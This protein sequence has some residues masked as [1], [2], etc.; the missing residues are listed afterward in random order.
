MAT[1]RRW[2]HVEETVFHE[3]LGQYRAVDRGESGAAPGRRRVLG[4]IRQLLKKPRRDDWLWWDKL[5]QKMGRFLPRVDREY[6]S[7]VV[8]LLAEDLD[9]G[10]ERRDKGLINDLYFA[11]R[12]AVTFS[13]DEIA[14][15]AETRL[16]QLQVISETPPKKR[17][18]GWS[19]SPA[20]SSRR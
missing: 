8:R 10:R 19:H 14:R 7:S 3:W 5:G 4:Q 2:H 6:G 18:N 1:A 12:V 16:S 15:F 13:T 17:W 11:R 20:R 9:P